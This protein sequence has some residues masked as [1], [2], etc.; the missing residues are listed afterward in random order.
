M[1]VR[2]ENGPD[3]LA[4]VTSLAASVSVD[5]CAVPDLVPV[6]QASLSMTAVHLHLSNHIDYNGSS[7][8][9]HCCSTHFSH[10]R[11]PVCKSPYTVQSTTE[12]AV[13]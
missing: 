12:F 5:S 13:Y 6:V 4:L 10:L 1:F 3:M 7:R 8:S 2:E 9:C 11:C